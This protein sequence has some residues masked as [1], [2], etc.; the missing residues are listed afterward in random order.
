M[1]PLLFV[2]LTEFNKYFDIFNMRNIQ[3]NLIPE[4][5]NKFSITDLI[6]KIPSLLESID[7]QVSQKLFP[8]IG[9]YFILKCI[10]ISMIFY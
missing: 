6:M 8:N 10:M 9:E 3:D 7:Y 2:C 1:T 4:W 5:S